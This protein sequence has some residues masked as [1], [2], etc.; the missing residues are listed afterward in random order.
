MSKVIIGLAGQAASGKDTVAGFLLP[1]LN[2]MGNFSFVRDSFAGNVK[3]IFAQAFKVDL[4]FIEDW[5]RKE[6]APQS[7]LVS[8]RKGL[9]M[10]GDGFRQIKSD[11][12]I[13]FVL[14]DPVNDLVISDVRYCNEAI[15]IKRRQ[16][17]N[18]CL[19]RPDMIN[20]DQNDSEK[21]MGQIAC[22]FAD[23]GYDGPI[24]YDELYPMFDYFLINDGDLKKLEDRVTNQLFPF[25]K[26]KVDNLT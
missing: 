17:L 2:N 26:S 9:Q 18:I 15:N 4:D 1:L 24:V 21:I 16:G 25:I 10:I 13:E 11:V 5:K 8:V 22:H 3:K 12:W 20:N 7:F 6:Q 19:I 23:M 14:K